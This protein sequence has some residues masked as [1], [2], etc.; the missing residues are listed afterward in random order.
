MVRDEQGI[1][2][3]GEAGEAL[4]SV[5]GGALIGP[6]PRFATC[7]IEGFSISPPPL[8]SMVYNALFDVHGRAGTTRLRAAK[9]FNVNFSIGPKKKQNKQS[10]VRLA[11]ALCLF[12]SSADQLI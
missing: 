6:S 4:E 12:P 1:P 11:A 5:D 7:A 9:L 3:A 2:A 10:F 8:L